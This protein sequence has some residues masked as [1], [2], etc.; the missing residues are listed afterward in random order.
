MDGLFRKHH[1]STEFMV[2]Q[3]NHWSLRA[4]VAS[5]CPTGLRIPV[6]S[7]GLSTSPSRWPGVAWHHPWLR[8]LVYGDLRTNS[9]S[10]NPTAQGGIL[11]T[12]FD[13][14]TARFPRPWDAQKAYPPET[15]PHFV[16]KDDGYP[17][18]QWRHP[19]YKGGI[20]RGTPSAPRVRCFE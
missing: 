11:A 17:F 7:P 5:H 18:P 8:V 1:R 13:R 14:V 19:S 10:T 15:R 20:F 16:P 12:Q 4:T 3:L 9:S 6:V 2:E